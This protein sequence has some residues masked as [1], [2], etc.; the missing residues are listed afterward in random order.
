MKRF[1]YR[2]IALLCFIA[3]LGCEDYL[4]ENPTNF[5]SPEQFYNTAQDAQVAVFGLYAHL[6]NGDMYSRDLE[7]IGMHGDPAVSPNRVINLPQARY[8]YSPSFGDFSDIWNE[9]YALIGDAN[10]AIGR[11]NASSL[12]QEDKDQFISEA[13]FMR[14]YAYYT[15]QQFWGDVPLWTDEI[16]DNAEEIASLSRTPVAQV[17]DQIVKDLLEAE[18]KLPSFYEGDFDK[19]RATRWAAK[20][21]LAKT[22]LYQENWA[23]AETVAMDVINNSPHELL[24]EYEDVFRPDNEINDEII[25]TVDFDEDI[26]FSTRGLRYGIRP[27]DEEPATREPWMSGFGHYVVRQSFIDSYDPNDGRLEGIIFD[28]NLAGEKL[29]FIYM[30]KFQRTEELDDA[31]GVNFILLRFADLLLVH[32]EAATENNN[33]AAAENSLNRVRNRAGLD[34]ITG[35]SQSE[36]REAVRQER[37]WELVGE[38]HGKVDRM[39][40]GTLVEDIRELPALSMAA[41][42]KVGLVNMAEIQA[43]NIE[44]KHLLLPIPEAEFQKNPNLG[45]QNPGW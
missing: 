12:S 11:L 27:V 29:N 5:I 7:M 1:S 35:L 44:P 43:Q 32:A 31:L 21:L 33:I 41:G 17:R 36:M 9:L 25:F 42:E 37:I 45:A 23:A 18:D 10:K 34:A 2:I 8:D 19:Q 40:W 15:L 22:Y 24:P 3:T 30:A 20:S 28:E 14:A 13:L 39:R 38:N 26:K 4:D 16:T 6:S